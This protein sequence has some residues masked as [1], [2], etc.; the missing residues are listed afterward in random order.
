M[1]IVKKKHPVGY[2]RS[3]WRVMSAKEFELRH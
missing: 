1:A 2:K 3:P